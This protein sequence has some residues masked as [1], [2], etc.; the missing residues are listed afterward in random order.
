[1]KNFDLDPALVFSG[2]F[3]LM[4]A[5]ALLSLLTPARKTNRGIEP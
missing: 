1:M 4:G 5:L 3:L 2:F